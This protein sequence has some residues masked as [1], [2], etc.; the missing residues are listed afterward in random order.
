[1]YARDITNLQFDLRLGDVL[2]AAATTG[3]LLCFGDL[4]L[5]G[6]WSLE[7]KVSFWSI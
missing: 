7:D 6:L 1:M 3:N 2:L 5:H 4:V